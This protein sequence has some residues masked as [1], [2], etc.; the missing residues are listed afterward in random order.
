MSVPLTLWAI[1]LA[2]MVYVSKVTEDQGLHVSLAMLRCVQSVQVAA[3]NAVLWSDDR[4]NC[5]QP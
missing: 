3:Y 2:S 4:R 1:E 5:L